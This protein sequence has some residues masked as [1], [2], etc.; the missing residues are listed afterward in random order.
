MP[1]TEITRAEYQRDGLRYASDMTD[2]EWAL[3]AR[4]LPRRRRL[5]RPREVDLRSVLQAILYILSTGCQW[6]ALPKEFPPYSTVQRYFYAWRDTG[7]WQ[8]IVTALVRQARRKLGRKP[9]PTAAV[10]DSQSAPT[11]QAGGPRG[12]DAGKRIYGRKRHIVTDTNG[13]LLA[14]HVHPANVQ[15]CHGAVPLLERLGCRFPKLRHVFADRIYRGNQLITALAHCGPWTI[16]I[17]ERPQGVKGFQLLPRRWVVE[18]TF[19]WF[20]RCRRLAKDFEGSANTEA[21]WLLVAHLRLLTR[22][23]ANPAKH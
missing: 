7:R 2:A 11:T 21:A 17:V 1:W 14:V 5:G 15:D 16:E 20:G 18:R 12:Y 19:A 10:V 13:L 8:K 3:I 23:L 4:R 22:R 9:S 6:R